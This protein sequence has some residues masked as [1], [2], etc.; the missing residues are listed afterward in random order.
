[1]NKLTRILNRL[2]PRATF[3]T[4]TFG[5]RVNAAES[6]QFSQ[7]LIDNGLTGTPAGQRASHLYI[8]NTCAV[9]QKGEY[10][11]TA[12]IRHLAS[13]N[14]TS[15]I[16]VTGCISKDKIPK[17]PNIF[18][19]DNHQKETLLE[20]LNSSYSPQITDKYTHHRRFLLKI[21]SGCTANCS[22]CLVPTRSSY[23][24][25]I[26]I[27]K[28]VNT[29]NKAIE[30]GYQEVIITGVN[31]AQYTPSLSNLLQALLTQTKI[32]LI[33]FG[34]LPLLCIDDK[35][36][37]LIKNFKLK[38]RNFLHIPLQ[39]GSDR[40]LKLMRRPYTRSQILTIFNR[41]KNINTPPFLKGGDGG[42][43]K[44]GTD[45]I[46]GF[47]S[48]TEV[49]FQQTYNLCQ[50]IGFIKIHVFRF[51]PRPETTAWDLNQKFPVKPSD[52][53]RRSRLLRSLNLT[54]NHQSP[55]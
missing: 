44:F 53:N 22:Y 6:N 14:P 52:V 7:L 29:V 11:S 18:H 12:K 47:P 49:D 48:E 26:A 13:N 38:I 28:A 21:Q 50:S 24:K 27:D 45:I 39:S 16:L 17:L 1:M 35:F 3:Q 55:T 9:T 36:L 51:S 15:T 37:F 19:I 25:S 40:I 54:S 31:L 4:I 46:V 10:E 34:S 5:C 23:L 33:S 42:G 32:P 20:T 41:L 43:F 30:N 2:P 8:I